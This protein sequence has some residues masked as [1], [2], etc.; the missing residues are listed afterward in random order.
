L[1]RAGIEYVLVLPFTREV[2][3]W[4][5]EQFVERVLVKALRARAVIVGDNFRFG[6]GQAGDVKVLAQ[7]GERFGFETRVVT[8]V[9]SR[10]RA[11]SSS[12]IRRAVEAG[13]VDLAA[14]LLGRPYGTA[15]EVVPGHGIGSKQTVPTLNLNTHAQVLPSTG[16]Y[17]TRTF[18]AE[19]A[20]SWN[21]ITNVGYR[22]T[23]AGASGGQ[24]LTIETFLLDRLDPPTPQRIRVEYLR[25]VREERKFET[26][27]ALKAQILRDVGRAQAFFRRVT[28]WVRRPLE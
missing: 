24:E 2:A 14:R 25:R 6:H 7:L 16:V 19:S 15:G 5:P 10:G 22:P 28:K 11:V 8:P 23:F 26:P 21:S 27:E 18:D 4:T 9:K 20:R 3:H 12:E 17:I 1:A 13:K